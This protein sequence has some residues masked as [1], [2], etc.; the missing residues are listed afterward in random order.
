VNNFKLAVKFFHRELTH[1]DLTLLFVAVL[2]AIGSLSSIGF[3]TKRVEQSIQTHATRL[4]GGALILKSSTPVASEW[5]QQAD[6]MQL[7]V[8]AMVSFPSMLSMG[9][10]FMLA[11]V[12]AVTDNFPLQGKL[13]IRKLSAAGLSATGLLAEKT[14]QA[15]APSAGHIWIAPRLWH[16]FADKLSHNLSPSEYPMLDLGDVQL[17]VSALLENI[18][19]QSSGT[20]F[21]IAP[22]ALINMADL[23]KTATLQAGSRVDYLYFF[24]LRS[25]TDPAVYAADNIEKYKHWVEQRLYPGQSISAGAEGVRAVN[26]NI[27]K[28]GQFLSLAALLSVLLSAIS[29]VISS[30]QY[31][32]RQNKNN[33]ILLCLGCNEK[34]ILKIALYK[35]LL[36][37]LI[38]SILG[39]LTGYLVQAALL[40]TLEELI[41]KPL[42]P[43]NLI[44]AGS[45]LLSGM[46]LILSVSMA[47]LLRIRHISPVAIM[48][49]EMVSAPTSRLLL[50]SFT[51]TGLFIISFW[52][53]QDVIMTL[54]FYGS[55]IVSAI[56]C[57]FFAK[58]ILQAFLWLS[59][60]YVL[61]NRLSWINIQRHQ[62][63]VLL[64][65][66][67]FSLIFALV[68][69]LYL[70]R[71]ELLEKWQQQLPDRTPNHFVIN[72]QDYETA[73]FQQFLSSQGVESQGI[74]PMVRG[75]LVQLNGQAV[76]DVIPEQ[77]RSHNALNRELN[78][79]F[80]MEQ[81]AEQQ[82]L[83]GH[84]WDKDGWNKD[85]WDKQ[86]L[87]NS[88]LPLISIESS[89]AQSLGISLEDKLGFQIGARQ[90]EGVVTNIRQV[91]WDSFKPNF[92]IIFSPGIIE[93]YPLTYISSFYLPAQQK[94]SLNEMMNQFPG[95]SI[96][97]VDKIIREIQYI[98]E[99]ISLAIELVFFFIVIAGFLVLASSLNSTLEIRL[100]ENAILRILGASAKMIRRSLAIEFIVVA[101]IS[102][103]MG[104]IIAE[105]AGAMLYRQVFHL[106]YNIHPQL[107]GIVIF[108]AIVL[109]TAS[110]LLLMNKILTQNATQSLSKG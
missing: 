13:Q 99:K 3:L 54:W 15:V 39:V 82:L 10:E 9:D 103:A 8:A 62:Q 32:R 37:G 31:G 85:G 27:K 78:L 19:G 59:Q 47:S 20:L 50:Y 51:L 81:E 73:A 91:K 100:Y 63:N 65:I 80:A 87:Q 22:V 96:I 46:L 101:I 60:R 84:W 88:R 4:S 89:L 42:P 33:A 44:P 6:V 75:R 52:T 49:N 21:S 102:A 109:I 64:Q 83:A 93:Q 2:I 24:N 1:G 53:T 12:K 26:R 40:N 86:I 71:T 11:H 56:V 43:L 79:S 77:A 94:N 92:Y 108:A 23:E 55:I 41:P 97:E 48:R 95:I 104:M 7:E 5:L 74:F 36:L 90:I 69:I 28:A 98:I 106:S 70:L 76:K 35:L 29:I 105:S 66:T 107:W 34:T 17:C 67:T 57:Y 58:I 38:A 18:P 16:S 30:Y 14:E 110:G 25:S 68:I 72:L 45:G 61:I